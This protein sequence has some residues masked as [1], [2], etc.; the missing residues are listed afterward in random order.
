LLATGYSVSLPIVSADNLVPR[1]HL[2][3]GVVNIAGLGSVALLSQEETHEVN[4]FL[5]HGHQ[6]ATIH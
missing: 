4:S 3:K 5:Q 2:V 1:D 6:I